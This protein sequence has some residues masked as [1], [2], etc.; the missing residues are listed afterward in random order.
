ILIEHLATEPRRGLT[1][2]VGER[3]RKFRTPA[4]AVHIVGTRELGATCVHGTHGGKGSGR[5][6]ELCSDGAHL[7]DRLRLRVIADEVVEGYDL[8][9]RDVATRSIDL[10]IGTAAGAAVVRFLG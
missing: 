3:A 10:D 7:I 1:R 5:A 6:V 4:D 9:R 8:P 2:G